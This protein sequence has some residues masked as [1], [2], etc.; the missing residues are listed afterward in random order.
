[1]KVIG[2]LDILT[3]TDMSGDIKGIPVDIS[4]IQNVAIHLA[5]TGSPVGTWILQVSNDDPATSPGVDKNAIDYDDFTW[6]SADT[7]A[8]GGAAGSKLFTLANT[9]AKWVTVFWDDTSG[10]G[11]VTKH[12]AHG[13]GNN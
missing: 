11:T 13:K 12:K 10:T 1:M 5:W 8:G 6:I 2:P 4:N 9:G 3:G 7:Q